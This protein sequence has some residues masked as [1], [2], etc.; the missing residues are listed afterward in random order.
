MAGGFTIEV[1]G[2]QKLQ[3]VFNDLPRQAQD[4]ISNELRAIGLEWVNKAK[5]DVPVDRARLKGSISFQVQGTSL[6]IVAQNEIAAYQEFGT[7]SKVRVP[8][9]LGNYPSEFKGSSSSSV[10]PITALT[11]W[12]RR[13]GLAANY[14]IKTQRR[15]SRNKN[16]AALEK[17]IAFLIF[18]KI[19]R[20]G[21]EPHPFLFSG[22]NGEDRVTF[23]VDKTKR[24][25]AAVL[26]Q[27]IE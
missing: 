27:I 8:A 4:G 20:D 14:S 12:V 19:R 13:K 24:N 10:D 25:I 21:I 15:T 18:R 11:E 2:L 17:T 9:V 26:Q 23:F 6:E 7:K 5:A 22:K 1:Q 3:K 16:E